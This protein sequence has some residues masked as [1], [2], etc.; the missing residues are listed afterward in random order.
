M[1][2]KFELRSSISRLLFATF[3]FLLLA[4][5]TCARDRIRLREEVRQM[6]Y[7]AYDNYMQF[8]FPHD[9]LKPLSKTYTDS[10]AELGNLNHEH[11]PEFYNGT[12]LTLVESLS[13]L[14]VLENDTEFVKAVVWLGD[15]LSF[16][17]DV[18]VNLFEN[19]WV[20]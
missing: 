4:S 2:G 20:G 15:N 10:L 6:F 13:S 3:S 19:I 17:V 7:H 1:E 11:L 18:R 16:D 5:P 12:A 8:A 9:E 14:A